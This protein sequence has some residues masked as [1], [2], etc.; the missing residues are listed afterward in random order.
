MRRPTSVT[1]IA[2][3]LIV[4]SG[5]SLIVNLVMLGNPMVTE[6][7]AKNSMP[8]PLQ[9]VLT[10]LGLLIGMGSGFAM[11]K[12]KNWGRFLYTFWGVIGFIVGFLRAP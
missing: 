4:V 5:I 2:W 7:M 8:L 9:Y 1:V 6:A 11:L 12:G 3:I 10:F